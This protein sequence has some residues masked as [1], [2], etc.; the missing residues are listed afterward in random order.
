MRKATLPLAMVSMIALGDHRGA[1]TVFI[2]SDGSFPVVR[3]N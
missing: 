2:A 3:A 1:M